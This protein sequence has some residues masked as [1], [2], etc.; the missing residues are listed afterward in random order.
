MMRRPGWANS[1]HELY[2]ATA[3]GIQLRG[4]MPE[5][6]SREPWFFCEAH[7]REDIVDKVVTAFAESLH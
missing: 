2:D 6:D 4:C 1:D 7:V 3:L 5:P